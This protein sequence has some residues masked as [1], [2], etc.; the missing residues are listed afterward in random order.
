MKFDRWFK[1]FS[2]SLEKCLFYGALVFLGLL[3]ISQLL[4]VR[5]DVAYY[6]NNVYRL[7][8]EPYPD[9]EKLSKDYYSEV[10][11]RN[12]SGEPEEETYEISLKTVS[13]DSELQVLVN[14]E[15]EGKVGEEAVTVEVTAGDVVEVRGE[16]DAPVPAT[17]R[18]VSSPGLS[19]PREGTELVVFGE[20]ELVGWVVP[21]NLDED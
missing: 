16:V 19:S 6:L 8:G 2:L 3:V 13:P 9:T 1:Q 21:E 18:V 11:R 15:E 5:E 10:F 17:V 4:M 12:V 20:Y 14:E 7:E